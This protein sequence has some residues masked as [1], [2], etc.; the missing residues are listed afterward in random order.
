ML[1]R[2]ELSQLFWFVFCFSSEQQAEWWKINQIWHYHMLGEFWNFCTFENVGFVPKVFW[3]VVPTLILHKKTY[4]VR[5][6]CFDFHS[7]DLFW[8]EKFWIGILSLRLLISHKILE[9]NLNFCAKL[10]PKWGFFR[11]ID[12]LWQINV[13]FCWWIYYEAIYAKVSQYQFAY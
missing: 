4:Q 10:I 9:K 12:F 1:H 7:L 6:F 11:E 13:I 2:K 8:R 5:Q 3:R